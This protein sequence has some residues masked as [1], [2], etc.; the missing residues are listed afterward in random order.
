MDELVEDVRYDPRGEAAEWHPRKS[1]APH[2][3]VNPNFSFG[4][5]VLEKSRIPTE[6]LAQAVKVEGS[7]RVVAML[8]DVPEKRVREAVAFQHDLR[9]AA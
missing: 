9:Q 2:V 6:T 4:R 7:A 3:L 1:T 8:F 5:P